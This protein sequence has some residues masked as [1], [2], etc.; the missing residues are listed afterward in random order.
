MVRDFQWMQQGG[1]G[2]GQF[3][4]DDICTFHAYDHGTSGTG[5]GLFDQFKE[6]QLNRNYEKTVEI[7]KEM[8]KAK[9]L[10]LAEC[11]N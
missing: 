4:A 2:I 8:N 10:V 5:T 1:A 3:S 6:A 11:Y 9:I 7:L